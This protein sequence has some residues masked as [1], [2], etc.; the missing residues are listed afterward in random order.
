VAHREGEQWLVALF[1]TTPAEFHGRPE[2]SQA[3]TEELSAAR[4]ER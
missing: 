2:V 3:L 1:Q 4:K